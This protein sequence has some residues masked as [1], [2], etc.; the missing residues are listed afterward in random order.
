MSKIQSLFL[1]A[2]LAF[3]A[4]AQAAV[5]NFNNMIN[6]TSF[7]QER[8][9]I[10]GYSF[11]S[12]LSAFLFDNDLNWLGDAGTS[13]YNN[14][15][16]LVSAGTL[17]IS[18]ANAALFSVTSLDLIGWNN[19]QRGATLVGTR[20]DNSIVSLSVDFRD[21]PNFL[22]WHD[23]DFKKVML[24]GFTNLKSPTIKGSGAGFLAL[25]NL[26]VTAAAVP[27]PGTLSVLALGLGALAFMRRRKVS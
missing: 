19:L 8:A 15:D 20:A 3:C 12:S 11:S 17:T 14:T 4:P 23:N 27:E 7:S 10:G 25:D 5:I 22:Y 26:N 16:Y 1:A 18:R 9:S 2:V 24:S 13:A 6:T 21:T